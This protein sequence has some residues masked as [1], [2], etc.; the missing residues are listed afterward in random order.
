MPL[1]VVIGPGVEALSP[2]MPRRVARGHTFGVMSSDI[3]AILA[4]LAAGRITA[5]QAERLLEE[6]EAN[7]TDVRPSQVGG[8]QSRPDDSE[9]SDEGGRCGCRF[10]TA[11]ADS[12]DS[13]S[14]PARHAQTGSASAGEGVGASY[15][16]GLRAGETRVGGSAADEPGAGEPY[17]GKPRVG[18]EAPD[19]QSRGSDPSR[20]HSA[21]V[22]RDEAHVRQTPGESGDKDSSGSSATTCHEER[23]S[24]VAAGQDHHMHG[25]DGN[26]HDRTVHDEGSAGHPNPSSSDS[27][28]EDGSDAP[29]AGAFDARSAWSAARQVLGDGWAKVPSEARQG[30][31]NMWHKVSSAGG[32][33]ASEG[34]AWSSRENAPRQ[35]S[36]SSPVADQVSI[37]AT[38]RRVR[39]LADPSVASVTVEGEHTRRRRGT[40]IQI[41]CEGRLAPDLS[42]LL[43]LKMPRTTEDLKDLGLGREIVIRVN[44]QLAVDVEVSGGALHSEGIE[45]LGILRTTACAAQLADVRHIRSGLVQAGSATVRGSFDTGHSQIRVESGNLTVRLTAE[46]NV[47]VRATSHNGIVSWPEPGD[48]DEYVVGNGSARLDLSVLVGHIA[49]RHV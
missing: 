2:R 7:G 6:A 11:D 43:R 18:D 22:T 44:P 23:D 24:W 41:I 3:P 30:L 29:G 40:T 35:T 27:G 14:R 33:D 4:D 10:S 36:T 49:V 32:P 12:A 1:P 39:L 46:A 42:G 48:T 9:P 34:T 31:T 16:G 45:E 37:Q 26:T 47:A 28:S 19:V 8:R 25:P 21:K 13:T 17:A 15:T 38:G 20:R 5:I